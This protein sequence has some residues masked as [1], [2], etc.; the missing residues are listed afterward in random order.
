[1]YAGEA[2]LAVRG[3]GARSTSVLAVHRRLAGR[4]VR[5]HHTGTDA[6]RRPRSDKHQDMSTSAHESLTST[7]PVCV[8]KSVL[9]AGQKIL[10]RDPTRPDPTKF[11]DR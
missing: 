3:T 5:H 11:D 10:T 9:E 6:L 2:E 4:N 7:K 8:A 1:M